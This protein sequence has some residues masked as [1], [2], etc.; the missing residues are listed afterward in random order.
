MKLKSVAWE[1]VGY[2]ETAYVCVG[3]GAIYWDKSVSCDC[4]VPS[5]D[6]FHKVMVISK[7]KGKK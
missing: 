2:T 3:C 4:Q 1:R 6:K 7:A 5:L